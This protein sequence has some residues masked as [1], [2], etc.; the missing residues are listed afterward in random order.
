MTARMISGCFLVAF[1]LAVAL[2]GCS[3]DNRRAA[4]G[5]NGDAAA[6]S[7]GDA[8]TDGDADGDAGG[9]AGDGG[10]KCYDKIDVCFVLD[11]ST[12]MGFVLDDLTQEIA[13]VWQAASAIDN[14]PSFGLVVFV[15]DAAAQ[16]NGQ[17]FGT[18]QQ[19]QQ[20]FTAVKQYTSSELEPG[21]GPG[22]NVDCPEN[23]LDAL[24]LAAET[25]PW[26]DGAVRIVIH[27]TDDTFK[28]RPAKL[29]QVSVQH[30]YPETLQALTSRE[31]RVASFAAHQGTCT[32]SGD[33]EAGFFASY[34]GQPSIPVATGGHV[35]DIRQVAQ[36]NLSLAD[37]INGVI[38]DEYCKP[39]VE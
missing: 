27:A 22:T 26:R 13:K 34:G 6:D 8:D 1:F 5:G 23:S 2:A 21:G 4:G 11:V 32:G 28:E 18:V 37:A 31:L 30:T 36:G 35:F 29:S 20:S 24:V 33:T 10:F 17:P 14:D 16:N 15:D 9:D 38:L 39:Y 7:G 25:F 12:S 19:I 3:A